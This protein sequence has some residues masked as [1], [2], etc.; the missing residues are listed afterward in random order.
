MPLSDSQLVQLLRGLP[1]DASDDTIKQA[2]KHAESGTPLEKIWAWA[3]KPLV[4]GEDSPLLAHTHAP[5][6]GVLRRTAEDVGASL[7]SP[8]SLGTAALGVGASAAGAKG[9]LGISK[10]ARVGEA[11]LQVPFVAEGVHKAVTGDS[12][13][14]KLAGVLEAGLGAHGVKSAATHAFDPKA[15]VKTYIKEKGISPSPREAFSEATA[16]AT[17]DDYAAMAHEPNNPAVKASY[18]SLKTQI[19]DQHKFL[20]ERAGVKIEPWTGAGEPYKNSDEMRADVLKNNRLYFLP[21]DAG[22]NANQLPLDHPMAEETAGGLANDKFRAVHDYF[23][24][25]AEPNSF[26]PKG[27]Q[28]AFNAHKQSL[29]GPAIP[30]LTTETRG[31]NSFV[32][33]GAHLRN[34][35]GD[36]PKKGQPGFVP[37]AERPF[38]P[39]K[40]GLLPETQALQGDDL[41]Q[42][43]ASAADATPRNVPNASATNPQLQPQ[44][45]LSP[46]LLAQINQ[47]HA[48][49][50]GSTSDL[51][52]NQ[53][54]TDAKYVLSPF[55]DRQKILDHSP[56]EQDLRNFTMAN[57]D[58]L[59][60]PGHNLGTWDNNGK[61]YLDVS[62]TENDLNKAQ[63]LGRQHKQLAIYDMVNGKDIPVTQPE[64]A[65]A[66]VANIERNAP[67]GEG[68]IVPSQ[69]KPTELKQQKFLDKVGDQLKR[70]VTAGN[71][72]MAVAGPAAASQIDDSDPNDPHQQLKHYGKLALDVLGAVGLG[73]T[74]L[75]APIRKVAQSPQK[76]AA[77]KGAAFMLLGGS[78]SDWLKRMAIE[79]VSPEELPKIRAASEKILA[80]QMEKAAGKMPNTKKLM[81][82]FESGKADMG[83]YDEVHSELKDLFG[84]DANMMAQLLA[85]TSSNATVKSNVTL[86]LKAYG[87]IKA[88]EPINDGFLPAVVQQVNRVARGEGLAGRKIDNLPKRSWVT[89]TRLWW[90]GGCCVRLVSTKT[91]R[92]R[93]N[94][95]SSNTR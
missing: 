13:G 60:Q 61:H 54:V 23:G 95:M 67:F 70:G 1:K 24:H 51:R 90:T 71:T 41:A 64:H 80:S 4:G 3:N 56:T 28:E 82:H 10:A 91:P 40:A 18:D 89:R 58:L 81:A 46:E 55:E 8:I 78:K 16:K 88:G 45:E 77:A 36:I 7:T 85:A 2:A 15:V 32:N 17:A 69:V 62:I 39:Q 66:E 50:G 22:V 43:G 42:R 68:A 59:S 84:K 53:L 19:D 44:V 92:P 73:N 38:A 65:A 74:A 87:K 26:G 14:E 86:A 31:Q 35:A 94:T 79:G 12:T 30:A 49:S 76:A 33:A 83:W 93:I 75:G 29:T 5:D 6:E 25:T 63:E 72:T 27:E 9:L 52:N 34:E 20:A 48:T 21:T 11:A 37:L 57:Q 47:V